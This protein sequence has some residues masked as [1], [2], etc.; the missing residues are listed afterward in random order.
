MDVQRYRKCL[1]ELLEDLD[2]D[3]RQII[4]DATFRNMLKELVNRGEALLAEELLKQL[5]L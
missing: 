3:Q 2:E 4:I 5:N 1:E